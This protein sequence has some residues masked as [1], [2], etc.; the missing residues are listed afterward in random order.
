MNLLFYFQVA[1]LYL[2]F[3]IIP[4]LIG[5]W[6]I[7]F[8][9][10]IL[11]QPWVRRTLLLL[12]AGAIVLLLVCL[13]PVADMDV[14]GR[15]DFLTFDEILRHTQ[16][17]VNPYLPST[18]LTKSMLAWGEG[19]ARQGTF[20]FPPAPEQCLDGAAHR[21][22]SGGTLFLWELGDHALLPGGA[23][24][25]ARQNRSAPAPGGVPSLSSERST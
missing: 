8:L 12:A 4:A 18:W 21:L 1:L 5:S 13:K 11:A 17:S 23:L 3:V 7:V 9:V 20:Y 22:R 14:V 2:P 15:Y 25:A 19:L 6:I 24:S 10:R 16:V